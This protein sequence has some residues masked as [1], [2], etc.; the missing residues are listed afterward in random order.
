MVKA[1]VV[2]LALL[3][4]ILLD[5]NLHDPSSQTPLQMKHNPHSNSILICV[6]FMGQKA[7]T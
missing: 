6:G 5:A 7:S 2:V 4:D 1:S 3:C